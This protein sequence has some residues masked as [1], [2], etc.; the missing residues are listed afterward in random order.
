M[1]FKLVQGRIVL[2]KTEENRYAPALVTQ[3]NEDESVNL[4]V[5]RADGTIEPVQNV[6]RGVEIGD[7]APPGVD[8]EKN[9]KKEQ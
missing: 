4:T 5:F 8:A 2:I 6:K 1:E 3:I 9:N 7:W